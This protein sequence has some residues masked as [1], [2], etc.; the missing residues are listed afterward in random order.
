VEKGHTAV[1]AWARAN[2]CPE[3]EPVVHLDPRELTRLI[4]QFL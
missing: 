1:A 3:P 2:G 4:Y